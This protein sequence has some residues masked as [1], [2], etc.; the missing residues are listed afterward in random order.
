MTKVT[1]KQLRNMSESDF[2]AQIKTTIKSH[3]QHDYYLDELITGQFMVSYGEHPLGIFD[4][5]EE[6]HEA[7]FVGLDHI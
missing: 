4:T 2:S 3:F 7:Y 5:L 6:G 1:L